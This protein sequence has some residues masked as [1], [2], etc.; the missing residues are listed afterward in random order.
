[1]KYLLIH[2]LDPG[3]DLSADDDDHIDARDAE[4]AARGVKLSG[5]LLRPAIEVAS[6]H[7]TAE[8]GTFELRPVWSPR[9]GRAARGV[10]ALSRRRPPSA[11]G[12][13]GSR[14]A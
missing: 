5:G 12:R 3:A 7:P 11:S 2:C 1:M 10:S 13:P 8:T 14:P 4:L 9:P 6:P